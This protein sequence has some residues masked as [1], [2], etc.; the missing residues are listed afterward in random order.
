MTTTATT[1][2]TTTAATTMRH[3]VIFTASLDD[4]NDYLSLASADTI[5]VQKKE[6]LHNNSGSEI[7]VISSSSHLTLGEANVSCVISLLPNEEEESSGF[8]RT[9]HY[10][11]RDCLNVSN[12]NSSSVRFVH[13][14][15]FGVNAMSIPSIGRF[16]I[17]LQNCHSPVLGPLR[18]T[19]P[20]ISFNV[21]IITEGVELPSL[22][23]N[24]GTKRS[25]TSFVIGNFI[26]QPPTT[27]T[28]TNG[29]GDSISSHVSDGPIIRHNILR[30]F[31]I[32]SST[33]G[34]GIFSWFHSLML[35]VLMYFGWSFLNRKRRRATMI[36]SEVEFKG[37]ATCP[38]IDDNNSEG[39]N[40]NLKVVVPTCNMQ[41]WV[42][43]REKRLP[44]NSAASGQQQD[45]HGMNNDFVSSTECSSSSAE[46][47]TT[48]SND[49]DD[50]KCKI[51]EGPKHTIRKSRGDFVGDIRNGQQHLGPSKQNHS[52][53]TSTTQIDH[54]NL[55][56]LDSCCNVDESVWNV[57]SDHSHGDDNMPS[58]SGG[59]VREKTAGFHPFKALSM[60]NEDW[61]NTFDKIYKCTNRNSNEENRSPTLRS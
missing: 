59:G 52:H 32:H 22:S 19:T 31:F 50:H 13:R 8:G 12:V 6:E 1:T 56:H 60:T 48:L 41:R 54:L 14:F 20:P 25:L 38:I 43:N 11:R 55:N 44:H 26:L 10:H 16:T 28:V 37:T 42:I 36:K 57:E 9:D 29:S 3:P 18:S 34:N 27:P 7:E 17:G 49:I 15:I 4:G 47:I 30:Q 45:L 53:T 21:E 2:S 5:H 58:T 35:I 61:R 24:S 23:T 39:K 40:S 46:I 51:I 33:P